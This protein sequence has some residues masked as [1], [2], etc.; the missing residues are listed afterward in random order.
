M[1]TLL[2]I[3]LT[4][5]LLSLT[6]DN[7][8][9]KGNSKQPRLQHLDSLKNRTV[10]SGK[11]HELTW[12]SILMSGNDENRFKV[13]EYVSLTGYVL[14]VIPGQ[15]ETCN[16][17]SSDKSD[18]DVHIEIVQILTDKSDKKDAM[19]IE[20]TRF[21][22]QKDDRLTL[23]AIKKFKE[24]KVTVTGLM[25]YDEEHKH[26]SVNFGGTNLWRRTAWEIHP[27][28]SIIEVK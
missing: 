4:F 14:L 23:D 7:C 12:D 9:V 24:K 10:I 3:L 26:N 22:S 8:P 13:N 19:I 6:G 5:F 1:K 11:I 25:F 27:C 21:F 18:L 15:P 17:K 16:C 2:T 28:I 20:V